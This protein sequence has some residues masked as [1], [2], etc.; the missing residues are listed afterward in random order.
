VY[1]REGTR[2]NPNEHKLLARIRL[3]TIESDGS[4]ISFVALPGFEGG[5][6]V[7]MSTDKTFQF[8]A[9]KDL[10]RAANLTP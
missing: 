1:A 6:F 8:Y 10:L 7:A 9:V 2:G 5:L 3:S 4:D